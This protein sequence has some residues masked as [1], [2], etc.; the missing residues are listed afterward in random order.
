MAATALLVTRPEMLNQAVSIPRLV[1][2]DAW[3]GVRHAEA[4]G[5]VEEDRELARCRRDRL[6]LADARG[7]ASVKRAEGRVRP[8]NIDGR[9]SE[10]GRRA[11]SADR[12]ARWARTLGYPDVLFVKLAIQAELDAAG[13][14]L[15]IEV[16]AA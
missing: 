2:G 13:I 1:R 8:S 5:L 6:G 14:K 3:V 16:E 4:E 12:A 7:Q 15:K 10:K 11:V 9:D